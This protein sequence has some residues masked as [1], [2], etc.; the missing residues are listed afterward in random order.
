MQTHGWMRRARRLYK[1]VYPH[2][3]PCAPTQVRAHFPQVKINMYED[4]LQNET[5]LPKAKYMQTSSQNYRAIHNPQTETSPCQGLILEARCALSVITLHNLNKNWWPFNTAICD[6]IDWWMWKIWPHKDDTLGVKLQGVLSRVTGWEKLNFHLKFLSI[7]V[8]KRS[9]LLGDCWVSQTM[10][11]VI[12]WEKVDF[13]HLSVLWIQ[14]ILG[15][16]GSDILSSDRNWMTILIFPAIQHANDS[17]N[18]TS[19]G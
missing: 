1:Q 5:I 4:H 18:R 3:T 8:K 17:K 2:N 7:I 11:S 12:S 19:Q 15:R 9:C 10:L 14:G 6:Q 16:T 13:F